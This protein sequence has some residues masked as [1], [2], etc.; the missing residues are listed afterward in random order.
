MVGRAIGQVYPKREVQLG[1]VVLEADDISNATEFDGVSFKLHAGEIIGLYGL[2]GAGR[3]EA[4]QGL[5][6]LS[7]LTPRFG[8]D[9]RQAGRISVRPTTPFAPASPISRR[10]ARPRARCCRSASAPT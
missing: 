4:M 8:Q 2:V 6:G 9:R 5:F 7:E 1:P 10:I 3:S